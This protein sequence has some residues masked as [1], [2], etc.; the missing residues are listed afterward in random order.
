M[1]QQ[2]L[3][4][5]HQSFDYQY[6]KDLFRDYRYPRNKI[7]KLLRTGKI[8]ALKSGLNG[9]S[10]HFGRNLVPEQD[11]NLLWFVR[12]SVSLNLQHLE[13]PLKQSGLWEA[14]NML[15][16]DSFRKILRERINQNNFKQAQE[17]AL[18]FVPKVNA[19]QNW[20]SE[21]FLSLVERISME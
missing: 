6:L 9:L 21:L 7:S 3:K 20:S 4:I 2:L 13:A 5:S 1:T 12:R 18:P 15:N 11:A 8:V 17:D 10:K 14:G 16:T 19:V